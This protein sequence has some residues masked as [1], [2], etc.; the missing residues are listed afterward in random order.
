MELKHKVFAYVTS[1]QRLPVFDHPRC[2]EAETQAPA[3]TRQ[4]DEPPEERTA[5]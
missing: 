5:L 1:G 3:G 2:P 4:H